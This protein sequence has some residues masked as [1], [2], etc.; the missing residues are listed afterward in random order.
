MSADNGLFPPILQAYLPAFNVKTAI[1][2]GITI[3]YNISEFNS[4]SDITNVHV[5]ITRQSNYTSL[6]DSTNYIKGIWIAV[7]TTDPPQFTENSIT[8]PPSV[9]NKSNFAFLITNVLLFK[10]LF[11]KKL[12][13]ICHL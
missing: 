6:F 7:N 13:I 4:F 2:S 3:P 8:I 5:S 11:L 1:N 10:I 9:F 12:D